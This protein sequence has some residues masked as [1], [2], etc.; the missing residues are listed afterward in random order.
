[1]AINR[2][3]KGKSIIA[4]PSNY[5]VLDIETTGLSS[6]RNKVIEISALKI[7]DGNIIDKFAT[8][9]REDYTYVNRFITSLTGITQDMVDSA[10]HITDILPSL[11][12]FV[13]DTIIVGQ[14]ISFDI[15]FLY[16]R[17]L[18]YENQYLSNDHVD[19]ARISRKLYPNE[20]HHRLQDIAER[21]EI[22]YKDAHRAE[23][24]CLI[25]QDAFQYLY[26]D[27][28][29]NYENEDEFLKLFK[30]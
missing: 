3:K 16:D 10:P 27:V 4:F 20:R 21:Y 30:K 15:N 7:A 29:Q 24:D 8:L 13:G 14:N 25:T 26:R 9:V 5:I 22:S 12:E 2:D 28:L 1:M 19:I 6:E 11:I 23:R 18:K 17:F